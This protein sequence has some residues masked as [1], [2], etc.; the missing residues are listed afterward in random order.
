MHGDLRPSNIISCSNTKLGIA[1]ID[2][3]WAGKANEA[4]YPLWMNPACIWPQNA[5]C[6]QII[7]ADH[8]NHWLQQ[9]STLDADI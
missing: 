1:V 9:G 8:D 5:S 4:K 3:D 6:G 7:T 2:Y